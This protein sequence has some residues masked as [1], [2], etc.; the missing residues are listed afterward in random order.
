M[1]VL[2][3]LFIRVQAS[4]Q[5]AT[6]GHTN[7]GTRFMETTDTHLLTLQGPMYVHMKGIDRCF[8]FFQKYF[9]NVTAVAWL[10]SRIK[11]VP[12]YQNR[13]CRHENCTLRLCGHV[14]RM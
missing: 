14:R 2:K 5:H 1:N 10:A 9:E 13:C 8:C 4:M 3:E 7:G 12:F 6:P 11:Q